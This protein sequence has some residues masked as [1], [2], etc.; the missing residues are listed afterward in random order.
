MLYF[1]GAYIYTDMHTNKQGVR[2]GNRTY[3]QSK[4]DIG[5]FERKR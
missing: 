3:R 5:S 2:Y 4:K 1:Y